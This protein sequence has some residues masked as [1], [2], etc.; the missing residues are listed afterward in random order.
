MIFGGLKVSSNLCQMRLLGTL[1]RPCYSCHFAA[2][3]VSAQSCST[4]SISNKAAHG[5]SSS[6]KCGNWSRQRFVGRS[7][8]S[9]TLMQ[10]QEQDVATAS[11]QGN[12]ES[13]QRIFKLKFV[14]S[15]DVAAA[16]IGNQGLMKAEIEGATGAQLHFSARPVYRS[17]D[18]SAVPRAMF[19]TGT[20]DVIL[21]ALAYMLERAGDIGLPRV[22][23]TPE[24][25]KLR[26]ALPHRYCGNVLGKGGATI[27][28]IGTNSGAWLKLSEDTRDGFNA[29]DRILYLAGAPGELNVAIRGVL[30]ILGETEFAVAESEFSLN[31]VVPAGLVES[32]HF[33]PSQRGVLEK[34]HTAKL[35]LQK[36]FEKNLI[37][38]SRYCMIRIKAPTEYKARCLEAELL[39]LAAQLQSEN[40]DNYQGSPARQLQEEADAEP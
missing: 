37:P 38:R 21:D 11:L 35:I 27:K 6:K 20:K 24:K 15:D 36:P 1:A 18:G 30:D 3:S 4:I 32:Q 7:L 39:S 17:K 9:C 29:V 10:A 16:V 28:E 34:K 2:S 33:S 26:M 40:L 23:E 13:N 14:V 31:V 12:E 22:T 8:V 5:I 19:A 25:I